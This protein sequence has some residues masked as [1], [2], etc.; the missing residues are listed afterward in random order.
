[1]HFKSIR[2]NQMKKI[3]LLLLISSFILSQESNSNHNRSRRIIGSF[4]N[5]DQPKDLSKTPKSPDVILH[6]KDQKKRGGD[7]KRRPY[8]M[9][10]KRI[11]FDVDKEGKP[12]YRTIREHFLH[13]PKFGQIP[14]IIL[15]QA[16][17][18]NPFDSD[19]FESIGVFSD[20]EALEKFKDNVSAS[21][22][23][24]LFSFTTKDGIWCP[25]QNV[26]IAGTRDAKSCDR[27]AQYL[28]EQE[29]AKKK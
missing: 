7:L 2:R 4:D 1:M 16:A 28:Q 5:Y 12:S 29:D 9:E 18:Y 6:D 3:G 11:Y 23:T 27:F 15:H 26:M 25:E 22:R 13:N 20:P 10:D 21:A 17:W 19:S 24:D 14:L 8:T